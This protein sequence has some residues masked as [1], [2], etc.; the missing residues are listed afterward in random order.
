MS[1]QLAER[2]RMLHEQDE[3]WG[4]L[5]GLPYPKVD[6][7]EIE[8]THYLGTAAFSVKEPRH[9]G[10][11]A[12][13][14]SRRTAIRVVKFM[15][16]AGYFRSTP[17]RLALL[18]DV[19]EDTQA[20][21]PHQNRLDGYY[22]MPAVLGEVLARA[23]LLVSRGQ[24]MENP[25]GTIGQSEEDHLK[26]LDDGVELFYQQIERV[27]A[28]E[29]DRIKTFE[30]KLSTS[31]SRVIYGAGYLVRKALGKDLPHHYPL[32]VDEWVL[33]IA[34]VVKVCDRLDNMET[35]LDPAVYGLRP[36]H[37]RF[38][39]D[40]TE[41]YYISIARKVY[42]SAPENFRA[43]ARAMCEELD[44]S[45]DHCRRYLAMIEKLVQ[46]GD[47]EYQLAQRKGETVRTLVEITPNALEK[48]RAA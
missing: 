15:A 46:S 32:P 26:Q 23:L 1:V 7:S 4:L 48:C 19:P 17:V 31:L 42:E 41:K 12:Y 11:P 3:L 40:L 28:E 45:I 22:R 9:T 38:K 13:E 6:L 37:L 43:P 24:E 5:R 47:L 39:L 33:F 14:H 21:S 18:H 27:L 20:A 8:E 35:Y 25:D 44:E 34:R 10:E 2:H 29:K 30:D 36:D 16:A